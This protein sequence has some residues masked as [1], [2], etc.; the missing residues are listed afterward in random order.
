[1]ITDRSVDQAYSDL[2][3]TSGGQREDY[4]GLLYLE[5]EH[6]VARE[7]AL[8]Q[9]AFGGNDYGVDGFHFD[10]EK[11]NL[12][13]F[14]FKYTSTY[15]QFKE[16]LQRLIDIGMQQI[17][18]TPNRD[19]LKNQILMQLRSCLLENRSVIE[20]VYFRF[21]FTG[22]PDEA[23]RSQVLDKLRE[24]LEDKKYFIDQFF[25]GRD[26]QMVVDFRSSTGRVGS[27]RTP[28]HSTT[29]TLPLSDL[30]VVDGPA[31]QKM[32]ICF[33]RLADLN[34]MYAALGSR[35]FDR[36]IR[37]G[38]GENEA[39]NRA[40]SRA[41]RATIIDQKEDPAVFAFN[42]NG[43]TLFAEKFEPLNGKCR[44]TAPRLL[45]GA[46]TVT[47]LASFRAHNKDNPKIIEGQAAY[48]SIRVLCKVITDADQEFV[49]HV[50][51]NN[52]RQNPV[53][54][55]NLHA[56]DRIQ[57]ELEDKF[58]EDLGIYYERQENAFDQLSTEGLGRVRNSGRFKSN[59]NAQTDA[60]ISFDR[61]PD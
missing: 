4:F 3:G 20:Q 6:R 53:E 35:F 18:I 56:N 54:P 29:F 46:Q 22:N 49:T 27:L 1:M 55:W 51:I 32:H 37:Y 61:R 57:L 47:T 58:R 28:R 2:K 24:D 43:I 33:I 42:H 19:N 16:S 11:K 17:F 13:V 5:R 34:Q 15:V 39:V 10:E 25:E 60:N 21:V 12:Y 36:N 45:N 26:V 52:N 48:E 38:L 31:K 8:N 23:E 40:I 59:S 14:Q 41:L 9:I 44:L 50:T 7:K 30:V